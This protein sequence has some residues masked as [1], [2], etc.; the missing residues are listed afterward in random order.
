MKDRNGG[1]RHKKYLSL[2]SE[3]DSGEGQVVSLMSAISH[4]TY[5]STT[6]NLISSELPRNSG[7]YIA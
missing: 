4:L 5:S 6:F 2:H 3:S 1:V 7:A